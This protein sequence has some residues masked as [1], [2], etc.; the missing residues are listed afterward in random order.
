MAASVDLVTTAEV[1]TYLGI[2]G[3]THDTLIAELINIAS[4]FIEV[5]CN[6]TFSSDATTDKIDGGQEFLITTKAPI[7]SI[8]SITDLE[9]STAVSTTDF[10]F[11]SESGRIYRINDNHLYPGRQ[12]KWFLG[13]QRYSV[14][15]QAGYAAV[16]EAVKWVCYEVIARNLKILPTSNSKGRWTQ[17]EHKNMKDET[18]KGL[19]M[20]LTPQEMALLAPYRNREV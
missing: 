4:E 1:K 14:V 16:P 13:K 7:I 10:D 9:D 2:S 12:P 8:T 3:S 11:Y 17:P 20:V 19:T 6:T 15:Y 18:A 5:Y